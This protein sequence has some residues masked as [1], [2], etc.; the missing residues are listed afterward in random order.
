MMD[1]AHRSMST[2]SGESDMPSDRIALDWGECAC[3]ADIRALGH[4]G[5]LESQPNRVQSLVVQHPIVAM[6]K[7]HAAC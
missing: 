1:Q 6:G 3:R 4:P 7:R 2:I 5:A